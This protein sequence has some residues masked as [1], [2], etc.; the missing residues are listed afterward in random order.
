M[1]KI[2]L[3]VSGSCT[4]NGSEEAVGKY[5]ATL[6]YNGH[7]KTID[8]FESHSSNNAIVLRGTIEGVKSLKEPCEIEV[9]TNSGYVCSTASNIRA[10]AKNGFKNK[11]GA[12]IA[13]LPLWK[14]L[15]DVGKKG[16]HHL[17]FVKV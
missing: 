11:A 13:N 7:Q 15:I 14:E 5:T 16:Q 6:D 1:K 3:F 17:V 9:K 10:Y 2:T 12:D 8:G 4:R